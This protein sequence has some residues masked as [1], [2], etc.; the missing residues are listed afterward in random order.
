MVQALSIGQGK[1]KVKKVSGYLV[2]AKFGIGKSKK[3]KGSICYRLKTKKGEAVEVWGNGFINSSLTNDGREI[4]PELRGLY[5]ELT[6][7]KLGK[8][9]KGQSP[10][11]ETDVCV[12]DADSINKSVKGGKNYQ[13]K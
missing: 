3:N 7:V 6:F 9:K 13:L 11:V 4:K 10:A 1:D 5:I 12:D 2:G 8:A